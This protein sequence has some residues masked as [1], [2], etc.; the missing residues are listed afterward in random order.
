[1][2]AR[3]S[4]TTLVE[5]TPAADLCAEHGLSLHLA[6]GDLRVLL[7]F[8]LSDAFAQNADTLGIDLAQVD[9]A[10]LSHAHYDHA[11]GMGSFFVRN[12]AAP[13][14]LSEACAETCWSTRGN[15][16]EPH[17]IGI[18]EGL[19]T[20]FAQRLSP[21]TVSHVTTIAPGVHLVPHTTPDLQETGRK[22]GMFL[23]QGDILVPDG[24]A[25][26]ITLVLE[27]G[28]APDA[29]LVIF[30]SCSHAG[31][32]AIV[33]EVQAAFPARRIAA[34]VGGLHLVHVSDGAVIEVARAVAEAGIGQLCVGHCTGAR[35]IELLSQQLPGRVTPLH[36]GLRLAL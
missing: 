13:L 5:N 30:N 33:H 23:M 25:H 36:T 28:D 6:Y 14:Y 18:H 12:A 21:V 9:L 15:T 1:M 29:P 16:M 2:N 17:Y 26:E 19:L 7:D 3:L 24:F 8:G 20:K 4:I 27:L 31:L 22:A 32:P 35:A 11:D 10:V 34:Y